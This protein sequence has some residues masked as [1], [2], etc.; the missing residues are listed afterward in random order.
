M[1]G[2][3]SGARAAS[4]RAIE[5]GLVVI[6]VE[7]VQAIARVPVLV[8]A[9]GAARERAIVCR[10]AA[11]QIASGAAMYRAVVAEIE[12]HWAA[13]TG[14]IADQVHDRAAVADLRVWDHA[15]AAADRE[16]AAAVDGVGK[17]SW[18]AAR[19]WEEQG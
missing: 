3:R 19:I 16:E 10:A 1:H 14:V 5:P 9:I 4:C 17:A 12:T 18:I 13:A 6:A 2:R 15:V 8:R 11:V 7:Q